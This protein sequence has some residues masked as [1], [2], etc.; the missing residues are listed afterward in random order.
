MEYFALAAKT[1]LVTTFCLGLLGAAVSRVEG[2]EW[3]FCPSSDSD[4][5]Q[6]ELNTRVK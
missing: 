3:G 2:P 5:T 6:S 1:F 4:L